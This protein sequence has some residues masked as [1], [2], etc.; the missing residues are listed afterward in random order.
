MKWRFSGLHA[1]VSVNVPPLSTFTYVMA[2]E[3]CPG[4][5]EPPE[6][7]NV[8]PPPMVIVIL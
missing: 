3:S 7:T 6:W 8:P 2:V 1:P 4:R 5:N